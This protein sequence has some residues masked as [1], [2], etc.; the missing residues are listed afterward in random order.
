[1]KLQIVKTSNSKKRVSKKK[2]PTKQPF[3]RGTVTYTEVGQYIAIVDDI[4]I[5]RL[6]ANLEYLF[7][8]S[9]VLYTLPC[10]DKHQPWTKIKRSPHQVPHYLIAVKYWSPLKNGQIVWGVV[11][12]SKFKVLKVKGEN[13]YE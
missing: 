3:I 8:V 5:K 13:I 2:S 10:N 7:K 12:G 6:I 11:E 4:G 1:M 9:D